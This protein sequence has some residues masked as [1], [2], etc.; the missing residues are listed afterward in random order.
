MKEKSILEFATRLGDFYVQQYGFAPVVGRTLG[1]LSV[2]SPAEQSI[3]DV[4]SALHI[5]R[6]AVVKAATLLEQHRL[7]KRERSS[8]SS[9]DLL[10]FTSE[11]IEKNGFDITLY[12]RQARLAREGLAMSRQLTKVQRE[13]LEK[14]AYLGDF[15]VDRIPHLF[16]EWKKYYNEKR[17]HL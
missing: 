11:H 17:S 14:V 7:I 2:C 5:S 9:V 1:F 3:N 6:T 15:L 16:E 8:G 10:Y 13:S 4:A 12:Q